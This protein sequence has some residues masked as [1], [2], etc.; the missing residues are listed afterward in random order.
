MINIAVSDNSIE[1]LQR[2]DVLPAELR[3]A[4]ELK[5]R[6]AVEAI[7]QKVH[8]II[9][10]FQ[11]DH[12]VETQGSLIIGWF[13]PAEPKAVAREFGGKGWYEILPSEAN[14]L[15]FI[16]QKDGAFVR[17]K[18]VWHPPSREFRDI[19]DAITEMLP[20]IEAEIDTL[21]VL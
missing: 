21:E 9:P 2:L 14:L 6:E 20:I 11:I 18:F 5:F 13:E 8:G 12:G 10:S 15:Q 16:G 19:R 4:I 17:T 3:A 7:Y 1:L